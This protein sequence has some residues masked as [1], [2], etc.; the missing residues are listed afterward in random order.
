MMKKNKII[1]SILAISLLGNVLLLMHFQDIRKSFYHNIKENI[2][3]HIVSGRLD[4]IKEQFK[5]LKNHNFPTDIDTEWI[6][7]A[8]QSGYSDILEYLFANNA[9]LKL[10]HDALPLIPVFRNNDAKTINLLIKYGLKF[11]AED[12]SCAA[13]WGSFEIVQMILNANK[14][15]QKDYTDALFASLSFC[16]N[17]KIVKILIK[18]GANLHSKNQHPVEEEDFGKNP[19]DMVN[20]RIKESNR[21]EQW[22]DI[23][24][25]LVDFYNP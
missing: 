5:I 19:I 12:L 18:K 24:K 21:K 14:F 15:S 7:Q 16:P 13:Y 4:H 9:N 11:S 25:M 8:L 17:K 3:A 20:N 1:L 23:R 22:Q 2:T 6:Y 10:D